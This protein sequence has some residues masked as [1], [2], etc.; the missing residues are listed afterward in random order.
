MLLL[1]T[2]FLVVVMPAVGTEEETWTFDLGPGGFGY[3][4]MGYEPPKLEDGSGSCVVRR[5]VRVFSDFDDTIWSSMRKRHVTFAAGSDSRRG[6]NTTHGRIYAGV[7]WLYHAISYAHGGPANALWEL[8]ATASEAGDPM[9]ELANE[10]ADELSRL[11]QNTVP[12]GRMDVVLVTARPAR[13]DSSRQFGGDKHPDD[14]RLIEYFRE[15]AR[16]APRDEG[17]G[18][19]QH[20]GYAYLS[21]FGWG[22]IRNVL[23]G[24]LNLV[25][26]LQIDSP[27]NG[28]PQAVS[29]R[30]GTYQAIGRH[31]A[32]FIIA[33][34]NSSP[35]ESFVWF[36]DNGQGDL[37][38]GAVLLANFTGPTSPLR[39]VFI[40]DVSKATNHPGDSAWAG[41]RGEVGIMPHALDDFD[42]GM[43]SSEFTSLIG[44]KVFIF[45]NYVEAADLAKKAGLID[46]DDVASVRAGFDRDIRFGYCCEG[47]AD[48]SSRTPAAEA[49]I[50]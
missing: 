26:T 21:T 40:H 20:H 6:T 9:R 42:C 7:G 36:G 13:N 25:T 47:D 30:R 38:T 2:V 12:R 4:D 17:W 1:R 33:W 49:G 41:H 14:K 24:F 35:D 43:K 34:A 11:L 16:F 48:A 27:V 18:F 46:S 37:C 44:D 23:G 15:V 29:D 50:P 39:G 45:E 19:A 5:G 22:M 8:V 10:A 28:T 31:K 32:E 3:D